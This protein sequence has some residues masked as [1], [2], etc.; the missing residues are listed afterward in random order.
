MSIWNY[1]E[2]FPSPPESYRIS[3]GEGDTPLIR[4]R[5]I[6]PSLGLNHL[7]FKLET[8][9][10]TGSFKDRFAASAISHLLAE[11]SES[12]LCLGTSSGNTGAA[13]AAYSAAAGIPCILAIVDTAPQAKLSQMLA[14]DAKLVRIR[15]FGTDPKCTQ[16]TIEKLNALANELGTTVQVSAFSFSPLGMGGVQTLAHEISAQLPQGADHVFTQAGGGG[17]TLAVARGFA[18]L[19][20]LIAV[21]CV[22]PEGNDTIATPLRE[23]AEQAQDC[24]CTTQVS[25][26]QVASVVDGN[27]TLAACRN[28]GGTG[29]TVSD[30]EVYQ[31]QQRLASEEGIF[32]EPA[33][34]VALVGAAKAI[35]NGEVDPD[36]RIASLITGSGFKDAP[37]ID[38]M[39]E[40][41]N[42]PLVDSFEAF[43]SVVRDEI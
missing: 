3:L 6:G 26:L 41:R 37:S 40:N 12:P 33:G 5:S 7:Y 28:S 16:E 20:G 43:E 10:P 1:N 31:F 24:Q 14:Y 36:A 30:D 42:A 22:Q 17:L 23:R 25:G 13:L 9:N 34:V 11:Q 32:A 21:H 38:R 27:E 4:S 35:E 8:V 15:N 19:D 39:I 2:H 29:Y 18:S